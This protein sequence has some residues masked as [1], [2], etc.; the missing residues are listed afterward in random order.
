[1]LPNFLCVGTEKAGTTPL[2]LLL[3]Q[4]PEVFI[5]PG[6]E[7]YFFSRPTRHL[8][9]RFYETS[10][11][12]G[13]AGEA[14]IGEFT[15]DY[16]RVP[17]NAHRIREALGRIKIILCLREPLRRAFSHY[18]HCLRVLEEGQSFAAACVED[19]RK[20]PSNMDHLA[21]R[22]AYV[23]GSLYPPQISEY[24]SEFGRENVFFVIL[25]RDLIDSEA[26]CRLIER[27]LGFLDLGST[28]PARINFSVR[29][30]SLPAPS[31]HFVAEE[32]PRTITTPDGRE[33]RVD[34]G[35]IVFTTGV[36]SLDRTIR[37]PSP[38]LRRFFAEMS[39]RMTR[40][41]SQEDA[42]RLRARYFAGIVE[43]TSE[44]IDFDLSTVWQ[45]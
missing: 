19:F 9:L 22:R 1:M 25:E 28:P 7:T 3:R 2:F 35:D 8:D 27:L 30:T 31:I 37:W 17:G 4:H 21:I 45:G 41:L 15:P 34:L 16:V 5:P 38:H 23:H 39:A 24:V 10:F 11:F 26:K 43:Q 13:Y 40:R 6:K 18:H 36:R 42:A 20:S 29:D 44:A 32:T 33:T 14:A 12:N